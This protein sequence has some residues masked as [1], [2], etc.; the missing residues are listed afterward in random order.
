MA[1]K[2]IQVLCGSNELSWGMFSNAIVHLLQDPSPIPRDSLGLKKC[3]ERAYILCD[4]IV[5]GGLGMILHKTKHSECSDNK[6][7]IYAVLNLV[8]YRKRKGLESDYSKSTF[9]VYQD[10]VLYTLRKH[11]NLEMLRFCELGQPLADKPTWVPDWSFPNVCN[12]LVR[13]NA[14]AGS[15]AHAEYVGKGILRATG[16][17]AAKVERTERCLLPEN[18]SRNQVAEKVRR[19]AI[20][21]PRSSE[22]VGRGIMIDAICRTLCGNHFS[23]SYVPRSSGSDF[24][25]CKDVLCDL[26]SN[27]SDCEPPA[28]TS[29]EIY[30]DRIAEALHGRSFCVTDKGYIGLA[31]QAVEA[32][33]QICVIS[34]CTTPLVLRPDATERHSVVGECYI[35]G[36]MDGAAVLGS[37]PEIWEREMKYDSVSRGQWPIFTNGETGRTQIEDPRLGPLSAGWRIGSHCNENAYHLYVNDET[38]VSTSFHPGMSLERLLA[39]GV[40]LQD[41]RLK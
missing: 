39:R 21:A 15:E 4:P 25:Q 20:L 41:F 33:D 34:G 1:K 40:K 12:P 2:E 13:I 38:G 36:F 18:P 26:L 28:A 30:L 8:P 10:V 9:E 14:C 27:E 19:I 22:Y 6:D 7:K 37:L 3:V 24:S 11:V 31:P 32:G 16:I 23:D 29:R 5:S 35:D 17:S